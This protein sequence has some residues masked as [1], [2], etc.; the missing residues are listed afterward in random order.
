MNLIMSKGCYL[1]LVSVSMSYVFSGNDLSVYLV[2][3]KNLNHGSYGRIVLVRASYEACKLGVPT[4][5]SP[6]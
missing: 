5:Q 1:R 6:T 2:V 3:A 4:C